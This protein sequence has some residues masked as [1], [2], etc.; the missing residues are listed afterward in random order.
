LRLQKH[1]G[2]GCIKDI[3]PTATGAIDIGAIDTGAIG[4][5]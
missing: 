3:Q 4:A 2:Y 1:Y 5:P